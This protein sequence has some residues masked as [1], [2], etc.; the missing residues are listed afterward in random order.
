M[1][2]CKSTVDRSLSLS[3]SPSLCVLA[4]WLSS[5]SLSLSISLWS[6]AEQKQGGGFLYATTDLAAVR[7]RTDTEKASRVI[8]CT[9]A[10][11]G[12]HFQQV[13]QI[14]ARAGWGASAR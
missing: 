14:A 1:I 11:Q 10:G 7:H 2:E 6:A 4:L 13:F 3:L 9:D 5:V 8:Y 12:T